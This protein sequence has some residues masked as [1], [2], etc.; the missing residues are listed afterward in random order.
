MP[1]TTRDHDDLGG[2]DK[3]GANGP[4]HLLLFKG[5]QI[6]GN[7]LAARLT[8][9]CIVWQ[10]LVGQLL[11]P[12]KAEVGAPQHQQGGNEPGHQGTDGDGGRHQDQLVA[13]R[14]L[15]HRPHHRQLP[16]CPHAGNLLGIEGKIVPQHAG[17]L[18]GSNLGHQRHVIEHAGN[19][20]EQGQQ[21]GSG[22]IRHS[23]YQWKNPPGHA[24]H[25]AGQAPQ[26]NADQRGFL[27]SGKRWHSV[28]RSRHFG[29]YH[30]RVNWPCFP[31]RP[32]DPRSSH[33]TLA[34]SAR[35]L[36]WR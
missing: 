25:L 3:V 18:L 22:H 34:A 15:G 24:G 6:V 1:A 5:H 35:F 14:S 11:R 33:A 32:S 31:P 26:A 30:I 2:E 7:N 9:C 28:T 13:K 20:I 17:R 4:L 8:F 12:L 16:L 10:Q 29:S 36:V 19:I 21:T 23:S 27:I